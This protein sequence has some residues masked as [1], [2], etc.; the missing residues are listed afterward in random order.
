[1]GYRSNCLVAHKLLVESQLFDHR[2]CPLSIRCFPSEKAS[3][4]VVFPFYFSTKSSNNEVIPYQQSL[5]MPCN[6]TLRI[7]SNIVK[8]LI[9]LQA[10]CIILSLNNQY[11]FITSYKPEK[12]HF[13]DFRVPRSLPIFIARVTVISYICIF[14]NDK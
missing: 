13:K 12:Q 11:I 6:T 9:H 4:L 5:K 2:H 7:A 14:K 8:F 1:M 3:I 10:F